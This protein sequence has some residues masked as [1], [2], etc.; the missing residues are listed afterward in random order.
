MIYA[1]GLRISLS[2]G[3]QKCEYLAQEATMAF[4]K[5]MLSLLGFL[6]F[7]PSSRYHAKEIHVVTDLSSASVMARQT[8]E[9]AIS[10]L[11]L[12]EPGLTNKQKEFRELIWRYCGASEE[13]ESAILVEVLNADRSPVAAERDRCRQRLLSPEFE[14]MLKAI[15]SDRRGR[16]R[17]RSK[18]T[19]MGRAGGYAKMDSNFGQAL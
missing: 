4:A 1:V 17:P 7:I 18:V 5:T 19:Q 6:R 13:L 11:Y 15:K 14:E 8:M 16:I 10:F 9:D 2:I 3:G 12:S